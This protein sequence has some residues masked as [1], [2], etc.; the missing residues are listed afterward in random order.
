MS[1]VQTVLSRFAAQL[2]ASATLGISTCETTAGFC[3]AVVQ[4]ITRHEGFLKERS[5]G[6]CL[7]D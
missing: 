7:L 2:S 6:R 4:V 3:A 5:R 1:H